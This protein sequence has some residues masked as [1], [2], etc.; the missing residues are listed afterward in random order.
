MPST[1]DH[2]KPVVRN[3]H[4]GKGWL[5]IAL[6]LAL[7]GYFVC[8][9]LFSVASHFHKSGLVVMLGALMGIPALLALGVA[10][11]QA[12]AHAR[13]FLPTLRW[14][15][16]LWALTLV[17]AMVFRKRLAADIT[18]D[19]LDGWAVFRVAVDMI[20][21]LV[22]LG[23]LA[24][25]RTHWLG[26]MFRGL[27]GAISVYGLV[28]LA[29]TAWSA[30][31][32]WTLFKSWEYLVDVAVLASVLETLDSVEQYRNFFNWTWA[33][34]GLLL[35]SVW[36]DVLLWP[37]E[38][39]Y[40]ETLMQGA[41]LGVRLSGVVPLASS[42]DVATFSSILAVLCLARLFP[43]SEE[44]KYDK[45]W[46]TVLFL[47]SMISLVM[48]QTRAAIVA[49]LLGGF[50]ILLFSKRGKLGALL[51]FI[52]A[53]VVALG[54]MG[55]LIW[56]FMERGESAAQISSLSNRTLWWGLAWQTFLQ[57]PLTGF[58]A[59][60]GRFVVLAKAGFGITGTMHSDYLEVIVG[61]GIWGLIPL[62]AALVGTWWLAL[63]Y[64]RDSWDPQ[65]R[66]L[67]HEGLAI[68]A[69]LALRSAFN[70][71]LTIHPALPF[72]VILGYVEFLRRRRKAGI[73][74]DADYVDGVAVAEGDPLTEP[75]PEWESKA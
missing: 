39:L 50:F 56:T 64:V 35:L 65:E 75:V 19:P 48:S 43:A 72:L 32:A 26:S 58:G 13:S 73:E 25:R 45:L 28:C 34:Y 63:R 71:M 68:L 69:L 29:S 61:T 10:L 74:G 7:A 54:T 21:A 16:L 31:P 38:A 3:A 17:S 11:R 46:Y 67:A 4:D 12:L 23:R 53:P 15:H 52:V 44:E 41:A 62:I 36:K 2:E 60:V 5:W 18:S 37:K 22:L 57:R 47:V 49:L 8:T 70:N 20:V 55:G 66:Q 30:F 33:L 40:G 6:P 24:L 9:Q 42:N 59:Y 27:V 14:W 1:I 51:T